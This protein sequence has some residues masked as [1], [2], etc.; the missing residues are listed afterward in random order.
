MLFL[1]RTVFEAVLAPWLIHL[2]KKIVHCGRAQCTIYRLLIPYGFSL[3]TLSAK[4][5]MP[6]DQ[7]PRI[8][9]L[10]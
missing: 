6:V 4:L 1:T 3:D 7:P 5:R 10:S 8:Y 2:P 9:V